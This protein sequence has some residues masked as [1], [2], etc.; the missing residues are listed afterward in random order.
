MSRSRRILRRCLAVLGGIGGV[1]GAFWA[2]P[3]VLAA[4][5]WLT[6]PKLVGALA[7]GAALGAGLGYL[8]LPW[9]L[10]SLWGLMQRI[11]GRLSRLPLQD[12]VAGSC[13]LIIGLIIAS[14]LS[15]ALSRIPWVGGVL[16]IVTVLLLGYLGL[17]VAVRK[18]EEIVSAFAWPRRWRER[19][20]RAAGG[21]PGVPKILDTSAVIDGRIADLCKTGFLEGPL[22]IPSFV[23]EELRHIADSSGTLKRNRGRRGL[24]VLNRLTK[25]TNV[26]VQIHNRNAGDA[27]EDVDTR[28][29]NLARSL[30]AKII[31]NDFNLNKVAQL[32]GVQVLNINELTNALKPVVLPGEEMAVHLIRD[33]KEAG[34]G[35]G[36]LDDGTMIVVDGGRRFIGETVGVT[37]TSVLQTAAGRMIFGRPRGS[38]RASPAT[39]AGAR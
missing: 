4:G 33:G 20:G 22:V 17:A 2:L 15:S 25:E 13:G 21:A 34:Q 9:V 16:P 6:T 24:D 37:V 36:Y 26:P 1:G 14:L 23:L 10:F 18:R 38:E 32:Q 7:A 5:V 30:E 12:I 35:V 31:T 39:G 28:L 19:G 8:V 27:L 29:V 11:E 3:Q